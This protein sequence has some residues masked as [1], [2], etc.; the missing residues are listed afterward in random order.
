MINQLPLV[1][2]SCATFN[3]KDYL[4]DAIE[5]FLMQ[6]TEFLFEILIHD[7][8]STDGTTEIVQ[9]YERNYPSQIYPVYQKENQFSKGISISSTYNWPRAQGKYIAMCEGDDY[10][11]D[12]FKL[13]KQVDFL[14]VN[15]EYSL[16]FHNALLIDEGRNTAPKRIFNNE[17]KRTSNIEDAISGIGIPTASILFEKELLH[18]PEWF[19]HIYNKDFAI[20]LLMAEKGKIGY[21]N[22]VMSVYRRQPGGLNATM[23]QPRI[24][25]H[26]IILL[27]YFNI[28]TRFKYKELINK[29]I[30]MKFED[31][32]NQLFNERPKILKLFS[33]KFWKNRATNYLSKLYSSS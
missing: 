32:T 16:C 18:I 13:Q 21:I 11:T 31:Y 7:D 30:K 12:P 28:H 26:Q 25:Q 15:T 22:E 5:G 14:E 19:M 3:H 9:E 24:I 6:K 17:Q 33:Y 10:W 27:S 4:R 29:R 2:I 23:K 1:S 8:A 20:Q